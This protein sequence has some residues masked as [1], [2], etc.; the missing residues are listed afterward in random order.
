MNLDLPPEDR[1]LSSFTAEI[2]SSKRDRS[3]VFVV[4]ILF[5]RIISLYFPIS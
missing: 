3:V 4:I 5:F 1:S 2:V